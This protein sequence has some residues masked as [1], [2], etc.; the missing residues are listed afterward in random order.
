MKLRAGAV[1]LYFKIMPAGFQQRPQRA[2]VLPAVIAAPYLH[3]ISLN[4]IFF[5]IINYIG[6]WGV[7]LN[8]L[9]Q[10]SHKL[11]E[12]TIGTGG[13]NRYFKNKPKFFAIRPKQG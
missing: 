5:S 13:H 12:T 9:A 11:H 1:F 6:L 4:S 8:A 3:R 10:N 7:L 2:P